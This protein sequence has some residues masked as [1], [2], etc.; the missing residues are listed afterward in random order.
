MLL[1]A[2]SWNR[3]DDIG[4]GELGLIRWTNGAF[5]LQSMAVDYEPFG[6][7]RAIDIFHAIPLK[8]AVAWREDLGREAPKQV[9]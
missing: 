5:G 3:L 4:L 6:Q 9:G 8:V 1:E 7:V 2:A